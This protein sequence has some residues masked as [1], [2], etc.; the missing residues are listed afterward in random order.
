MSEFS[1]ESLPSPY[2]RVAVKALIFNA[3]KQ[4]LVVQNGDGNWE[5]PG[6]GWEYGE[7]FRDCLDREI[8][9][10]LGVRVATISDIATTY[11][12]MNQN[13]Y[14]AL[15]LVVVASLEDLDFTYGDGML[16]TR[17]VGASELA[18]L[19]MVTD[20]APIKEISAEIWRLSSVPDK[21]QPDFS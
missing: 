13:G 16:A 12:G 5:L 14:M 18:E 11:R 7:S 2:Y 20:D 3:E 21:T 1:P 10:E 4:L 15:R 9:E 6:G 8:D 19:Q 17:F